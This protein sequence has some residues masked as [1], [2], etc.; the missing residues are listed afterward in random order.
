M[1]GS[2]LSQLEQELLSILKKEY[3]FYQSLYILLDKQGDIIKY[4]SDDNLLE[5]YAEIE[6]CQRRIRESETKIHAI[7]ER[8]AQLFRAAS[9]HPEIKKVTNCIITLVKKNIKLVAE[10]EQYA[11]D[12][13][14]RIKG[15]LE[16]LRNSQKI[17]R[18][19]GDANAEPQFVD[20]KQ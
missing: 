7:K 1:A 19:I 5:L 18:Y 9:V 2:V 16:E 8:N 4:D 6:R 14:R 12:R 17:L 20:G 13:H 15:E 10:N 3:S 11:R